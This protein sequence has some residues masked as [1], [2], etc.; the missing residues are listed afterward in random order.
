MAGRI[1]RSLIWEALNS[2]NFRCEFCDRKTQTFCIFLWQYSSTSA[3]NFEGIKWGFPEPQNYNPYLVP[4]GV[5]T[6]Y[7]T[8]FSQR[9]CK[10]LS[11]FHVS[12]S[13]LSALLSQIF[14]GPVKVVLSNFKWEQHQTKN[15]TCVFK[16]QT[17]D[18]CILVHNFLKNNTS[19]HIC[20]F[21]GVGF[22]GGAQKFS[23]GT[24][25]KH[26]TFG[27]SVSIQGCRKNL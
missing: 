18:D 14:Q 3:A 11:F 27:C 8:F 13:L 9:L 6:P 7:S 12:L 21:F 19:W 10:A 26:S 20:C 24:K 1:I 5:T 17:F 4:C 2:P 23:P 25:F 22:F 16:E 15:Q